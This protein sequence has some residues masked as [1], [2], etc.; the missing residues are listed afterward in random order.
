[1][2][3]NDQVV[4]GLGFINSVQKVTIG[5]GNDSTPVSL[6][7]FVSGQTNVATVDIT[8]DTQAMEGNAMQ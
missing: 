4:K 8:E 7:S 5:H 1:M 2:L 3:W 6:L